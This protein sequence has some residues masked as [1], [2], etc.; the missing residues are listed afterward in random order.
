M[1][2]FMFFWVTVI[3]GNMVLGLF[4]NPDVVVTG[5]G[6]PALIIP[7]LIYGLMGTMYCGYLAAYYRSAAEWTRVGPIEFRLDSEMSDWFG[8]YARTIG[9]AIITLGLAMIVYN[10]RKWRFIVDRLEAYGIVD[11]DEL[12]QS[13]TTAPKEAEGFLDALDIGAF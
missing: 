10:Y 1:R 6:A 2:P 9:L 5:P 7:L 3:A 11:L 12:T 8:F 13:T 4:D